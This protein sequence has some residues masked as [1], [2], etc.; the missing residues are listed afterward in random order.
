M[1]A[2]L[3]DNNNVLANIPSTLY[4]NILKAN[5]LFLRLGIV[6]LS[7]LCWTHFNDHSRLWT[8]LRRGDEW[9]GLY[10][11]GK[12]NNFIFII[13]K[14]V[15][16]LSLNSCPLS[17]HF[18]RNFNWHLVGNISTFLHLNSTAQCEPVLLSSFCWISFGFLESSIWLWRVLVSRH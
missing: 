13:Y 3:Q 11:L 18:S 1:L 4:S 17:P 6:H 2:P 12:S 10:I 15:L 5:V 7:L 8:M 16:A 9:V 14:S